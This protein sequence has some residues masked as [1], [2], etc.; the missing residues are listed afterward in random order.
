MKTIALDIE[1][2]SPEPITHGVYK[3]AAHPEFKVLLFAYSVDDG[4]VQLADLDNGDEIPEPISAALQ[5]PGVEKWAFNANFER[6][7]LSRHILGAG[8]F[9]DPTGWRCSMVWAG[10]L[11][12]PTSLDAVG[13]A[14]NLRLKKLA[15]GK[16]LIKFFCL[17]AESKTTSQQ[18][19]ALLAL[20]QVQGVTPRRTKARFPADWEAFRKY[21]MRD[22]ETENELRAKLSALPLP[23]HVWGE[24]EA[25]Q[26]INDRG[27]CIDLDFAWAALRID[28]DYRTQCLDE[29]QELTGLTNPNSPTQLL[30]WLKTNGLELNDL[31]KDTVAD[32]IDDAEGTVK[33][34]LELRQ[35]LS[36]SSVKKYQAMLDTTNVDGRAHGLL[37]FYGAG[38]TGRWAGRKIQVQNLPRNYLSDL[39]DARQVVATGDVELVEVFYDNVPDTLS[40]LIRTAFIPKP[41]TRFIVADYSAIEARVLAWLAGEEDTLQAFRDGKDLYCVTASSMFGVPVEKHG[42][43]AELRQKGKVATLACIAEGQRVLTNQGEI[44]IE[45][46]T[47]RHKVWDGTDFVTHEGLIYKGV[48]NVITYQGL[49]ATPDHIVWAEIEGAQREIPF[50]HAATIGAHLVQSGSG[51]RPVRLGDDNQPRTPLQQKLVM[52][53][54]SHQVRR[55]RLRTMAAPSKSRSGPIPRMP[56]LQSAKSPSSLARSA[57]DSCEAT[58]CK[59]ERSKLAALWRARYRISVPLRNGSRFLGDPKSWFTPGAGARSYQQPGALRAR[60]SS[61]GDSFSTDV[62]SAQKLCGAYLRSGGMALFGERGA[63]EVSCGAK[64]R[65]G[66]CRCAQSCRRKAEKLEK[67][68]KKAR[69]Y[70]IVNSGPRNRFT[71]SGKLVHNCGYQGGENALKAMGALRMGI[72]ETELKPIVD[73]W[74]QANPHIVALWNSTNQAAINAIKYGGHTYTIDPSGITC[75]VVSGMLTITLPSGRRLVYPAPQIGRN[76][77][78]QEAVTFKGVGE[79]RQFVRGETYGG[80]LVENITQAVARDILAHALVALEEQG[81]RV[82]FHVHDEVVVEAPPETTVDDICRLLSTGPPWAGG[83]PLSADGFECDYYQKD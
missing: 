44:P 67:H 33:R 75:Q 34:V 17:P 32:A 76:R 22:V 53:L 15:T 28:T 10:A 62:Q 64:P 54:R 74:R 81:H 63:Q 38:R 72:P 9:L 13:K 16:D 12:L 39:Y 41:G 42:S 66:S 61:L 3:Y 59:S 46:V 6:V 7:C 83:L 56:K 69:V 68:P 21:N 26:R 29:A 27:V 20:D 65:A 2:F 19:D 52:L 14:L 25:D 11:G 47:T 35:E 18:T 70:D 71:V 77:F 49:T 82:V 36:R 79:N 8:G 45:Q 78:G 43:N 23:D 60:E 30:A 57:T 55:M 40:Q 48:K 31:R 58:V 4:P 50:G 73:A 51:G 5:D 80:K 1:T 37:Q 24:Y